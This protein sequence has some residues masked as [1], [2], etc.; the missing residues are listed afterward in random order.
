MVEINKFNANEKILQYQD[1]IHNYKHGHETLISFE[2]DLTN[3]CNNRCPKCVGVKK[4]GAE[5]SFDQI[6]SLVNQ[7]NNL[8]VKSVVISGGGEPLLSQYF[9]ETLYLFRNANISVGLNSNGL[10][11][12]Y[13][14]QLRAIL[15]CC[16]YIRFS[17]D[18]GTPEMYKLTHGMEHEEFYHVIDNITDLLNLRKTI[19]SDTSIGLGYLT[20][21]TTLGG[22]IDFFEISDKL[23]VDFAQLRPF[24]NE[25]V[26][27]EEYLTEGRKLFPDLVIRSSTHKYEHMNDENARP[28]KTCHGMY[29]N[30]VITAD[31]K[32]WSCIHHR[33]DPNYFLGDLNKES[34]K[35]ILKSDRMK[36][37]QSSIT[38]KDCPLFCRNDAI[39][40][41]LEIVYNDI[42]HKEFL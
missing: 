9:V 17:L 18:A 36:N 7:M 39:N 32:M 26:N 12:L 37:V 5:L 28:Y 1:K 23:K 24:T 30:T 40:R 22:I 10:A 3:K 42:V 6:K 21:E 4:G 14:S 31:F 29:F 2:L 35:D 27:I 38:F 25:W 20:G 41:T 8:N 13:E 19:D 34:I 15:E 33:Q 16:K 11:M